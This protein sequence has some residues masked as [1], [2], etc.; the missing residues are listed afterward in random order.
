M[1]TL[2][3]L[4]LALVASLALHLL[5]ATGTGRFLPSFEEPIEDSAQSFLTARLIAAGSDFKATP[6]AP[7]APPVLPRSRQP[8]PAPKPK[9]APT[10]AEPMPEATL[11]SPPPP[12]SAP[13]P[14]PAAP[15]V[16]PPAAAPQ[17]PMPEAAPASAKAWGDVA[18]PRRVRLRYRAT[19]GDNGFIVGETT[20]ELRH[21]G[22]NYV[23]TRVAATTGLAGIFRPTKVVE[24]SEGEI[25][26]NGFRPREFRIDRGGGR[27][28]SARFDWQAAR[29]TLSNERAF[30]LP[31][32]AQDLLSV[33]SQVSLRETRGV[34]WVSLPVVT[35]KRLERYDFEVLGE[36]KITTPRGERL[37]VHL[38][39]ARADSKEATELWLSPED[40]NLPVKVRYVDRRGEMFEQVA[41]AIEFGGTTEGRRDAH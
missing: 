27:I 16:E 24:T 5:V 35:G 37:T 4:W 12:D 22:T 15:P 41:E 10:P 2:R 7:A 20:Q 9:P 31:L 36:E 19:M 1:T 26:V 11:P 21:D 14:E 30:E 13:A 18:F 28:E 39:N 17:A 38:R 3:R 29:V 23:L 8:K 32:G 34:A 33:F 40:A 25:T 6:V